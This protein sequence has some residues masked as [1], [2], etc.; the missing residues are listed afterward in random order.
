M[1]ATTA[2]TATDWRMRRMM[3]A[4]TEKRLR[5]RP[6]VVKDRVA[7]PADDA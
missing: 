3:K 2:M 6:G 5:S 4:S 1:N 7:T